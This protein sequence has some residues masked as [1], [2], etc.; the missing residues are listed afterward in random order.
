MNTK[1]LAVVLG[2]LISR[3]MFAQPALDIAEK[4][5]PIMKV[6]GPIVDASGELFNSKGQYKN[7]RERIKFVAATITKSA[8]TAAAAIELAKALPQMET[9]AKLFTTQIQ[10][11]GSLGSPACSVPNIGCTQEELCLAQILKSLGE[12]LEPIL[13]NVLGTIITKDGQRVLTK[14][15]SIQLVPGA[16]ASL[17]SI[18]PA[19]DTKNKYTTALTAFTVNLWDAIAFI[20][21][22]SDMLDPNLMANDP[23]MSAGVKESL[24]AEPVGVAEVAFNTSPADMSVDD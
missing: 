11:L 20:K 6:V 13:A 12:L 16:L 18:L 17:V 22:L 4:I 8:E 21:L 2:A 15:G 10:C 5:P 1:I 24:K 3:T 14:A 19:S 7:L 23:T 9:K